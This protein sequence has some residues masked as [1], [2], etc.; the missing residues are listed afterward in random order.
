VLKTPAPASE[1]K[2]TLPLSPLHHHQHHRTENLGRAVLPLSRVAAH[3][4]QYAEPH[5]LRL[6]HDGLGAILSHSDHHNS[7]SRELEVQVFLSSKGQLAAMAQKGGSV[8]V[9]A[10]TWNVGNALP[11]PPQQLASMWLRG[12][13]DRREHHLVAVSAQECSYLKDARAR[14]KTLQTE[15]SAALQPTSSQP[16][17]SVRSGEVLDGA[18][19]GVHAATGS[20]Q[21]KR[22]QLDSQPASRSIKSSQA[23]A[24]AGAREAADTTMDEDDERLE[25]EGH[26]EQ[27]QVRGLFD[28][29][30]VASTPFHPHQS[31]CC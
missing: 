5:K 20:D 30:H 16:L 27:A 25:E 12:T 1:H 3:P 4:D 17:A 21:N 18:G 14:A 9:L 13:A 6:V 2:S 31:T 22:K 8:S 26:S 15:G 11:P 7:S 10:A 29:M 28:M 24:A 23:A 19:N